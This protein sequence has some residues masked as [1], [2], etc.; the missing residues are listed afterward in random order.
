VAFGEADLVFVIG[1]DAFLK[2]EEARLPRGVDLS[3][4]F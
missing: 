1:Q 2:D 4:L 3:F